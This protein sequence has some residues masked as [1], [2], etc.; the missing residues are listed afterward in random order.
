MTIIDDT[1]NLTRCLLLGIAVAF[2]IVPYSYAHRESPPPRG[3]MDGD[4]II[5]KQDVCVETAYGVDYHKSCLENAGLKI[6]KSCDFTQDPEINGYAGLTIEDVTFRDA[7]IKTCSDLREY[8]DDMRGKRNQYEFWSW[9]VGIIGFLAV[10]ALLPTPTAGAASTI[11]GALAT[12][13]VLDL[14][15][16][17]GV[18]RNYAESAQDAN[19]QLCVG[20]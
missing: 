17:A 3:D 8:R 6:Q 12:I 9:L 2:L 16:L 18:Y 4:E 1:L 14:V 13:L 15:R 7:E 10:V 20:R 11:V 19:I 5:N